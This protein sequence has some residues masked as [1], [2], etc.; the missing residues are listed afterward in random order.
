MPLDQIRYRWRTRHRISTSLCADIPVLLNKLARDIHPL[1]IT[2]TKQAIHAERPPGSD[3]D[4]SWIPGEDW[5]ATPY[6]VCST[7][8]CR[9]Q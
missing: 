3:H 2:T 5:W 7:T 1:A 8:H 9:T 6:G 4:P